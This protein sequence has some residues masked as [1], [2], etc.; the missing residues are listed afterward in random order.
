MQAR[1]YIDIPKQ[2]R[3]DIQEKFGVSQSA[4]SMAL[5][6]QRN[7]GVSEEI[8]HYA[9]NHP[10]S[11]KMHYIPEC[12]TIHDKDGILRQTF[13]NGWVLIGDKNTGV[14]EVFTAEGKLDGQ[15]FD[16]TVTRLTAIQAYIESQK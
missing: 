14:V 15:Y 10:E 9:L 12:E 1:R 13:R 11:E 2:V 5:S 16:P 6:Y 8:Q 3:R 4:I 7:K